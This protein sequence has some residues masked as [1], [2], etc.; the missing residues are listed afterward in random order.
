MALAVLFIFT[1]ITVVIINILG[2]ATVLRSNLYTKN[3]KI[4][5]IL[6]TWSIPLV[7][8]ISTIIMVNQDMKNIKNE[9]D[10]N[11]IAALNDFTNRVN[12]ISN[13]IKATK[14]KEEKKLH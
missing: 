14:E 6:F 5:Y 11:L 12:S 4:L 9:S 3:K 13:G 2:T 7:G 1:G 8:A 10:D